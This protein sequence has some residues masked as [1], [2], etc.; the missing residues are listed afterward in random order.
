MAKKSKAPVQWEVIKL[1]KQG[2]ML[3]IVYAP[4]EATARKKT[5]AEFTVKPLQQGSLLIRKV[6]TRR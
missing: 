1:G 4:N 6:G 5:I 3:G 2:V